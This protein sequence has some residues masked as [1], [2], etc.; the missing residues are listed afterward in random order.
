MT[1]DSQR[2]A[3]ESALAAVR[4]LDDLEKLREH[5]LGRKGGEL[6]KQLKTLGTL[7]DPAERKQA[8]E[9]INALK[10]DVTAALD[11]RRAELLEVEPAL[12][13]PLDITAPGLRPRP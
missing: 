2:T 9:R 13:S 12:A 5:W 4:S 7:K 6:T 8:G 3:F 11:A 1:V 10:N